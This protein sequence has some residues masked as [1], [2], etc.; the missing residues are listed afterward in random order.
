MRLVGG[1]DKL[2]TLAAALD[3]PSPANHR[4]LATLNG[5]ILDAVE[6]LAAA[7]VREAA[8]DLRTSLLGTEAEDSAVANA[9]VSFDGSWSIQG[10]TAR[11]GFCSV[12]SILNKKVLDWHTA[13]RD[14]H[15]CQHIERTITDRKWEEHHHVWKSTKLSVEGTM[16]DLQKQ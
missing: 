15:R 1:G 7:S 3:M 8:A 10:F 11:Y 16:Q 12:I 2:S 6:K 9:A 5:R 4:I 13:S 14:C